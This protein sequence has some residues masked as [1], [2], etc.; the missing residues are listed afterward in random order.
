MGSLTTQCCVVGGGPAGL[1]LGFLLARQGVDVIV[2]EKHADFLRDFRGDTVH[3]STLEIFHELGLLDGLLARPHQKT[4][5]LSIVIGGKNFPVADFAK[6]PTRCKYIAMMPQWEFLNFL[7]EE[8]R[9]LPNF[10]LLMSTQA[11]SLIAED[12]SVAG[13]IATRADDTIDIRA[14]LTVAADGRD[15]KLRAV[16][17]LKVEDLGA[18]IDVFWMKLAKSAHETT[19]SL[20]RINS[21]GFLVQINRGDHWQ[22]ALPFPKGSAEAIREDG[23]GKFRGRIAN[24]APTLAKAAEGLTSWDQI[25]LLTVQVNHLTTWW[26][27]GFLCIGDAAHAMSPV[28]GVGVNLAVQDAVAS[29]RILGPSLK[30][31]TAPDNLLRAVQK[32]RAWPARMTQRAQIAAHNRILIPAITTNEPPKAPLALR[33]LG[34]IPLLTGLTARALGLGLRPEHWRDPS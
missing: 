10:R 6:L 23:L 26:T 24:I 13:V 4:E 2:L 11:N 14:A 5:A 27:D 33:M 31:G 21:G 12:G 8:A 30:T 25:K 34:R 19:D 20:A 15:S 32:R 7:S 1:M 29:A 3:P 18:P 16:S 28:G 22:C 9:R 17:G